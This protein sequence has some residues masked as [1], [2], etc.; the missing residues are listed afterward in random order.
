MKTVLA[1]IAVAGIAATAAQADVVLLVD[2]ST[3]DQITISAAPGGLSAVSAS[4]SNTTGVYLAGILGSTGGPT[5]TTIGTLVGTADLSTFNNPPD[6]TPSLYRSSGT[7]TGLNFWSFSTSSTVTF[8][9][10]SQAFAGSATWAVDPALYALLLSGAT[11]GNVY[12]PA[13]DP[14][15]LPT[16]QV[17]GQYQ[18]VPAPS[19]LAL[20]GLGG[21]VATRRRR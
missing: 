5:G 19:A 9:A 3:P 21:L 7:D 18:V 13:D 8:T 4:G 15:D 16:A 20:L 1:M 10:G 14:A 6:G 2:L 11:S 12:F 17:I